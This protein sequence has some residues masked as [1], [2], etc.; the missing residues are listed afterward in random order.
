MPIHRHRFTASGRL[1]LWLALWLLATP[2]LA[3]PAPERSTAQQQRRE[4]LWRQQWPRFAARFKKLDD[5]YYYFPVF[6]SEKANSLDVPEREIRDD[7]TVEY[8]PNPNKLTNRIVKLKVSRPQEDIDVAMRVL[9][10]YRPGEYGYIHSC[11]IEESLGEGSAIVSDI[12]LLDRQELERQRRDAAQLVRQELSS[13][14][15][16]R[17]DPDDVLRFMFRYRAKAVQLEEQ[18]ARDGRLLELRGFNNEYLRAQRVRRMPDEG[19]WVGP[20]QIAIVGEENG[21]LIAVPPALLQPI[22]TED[23][24]LALLASHNLDREKFLDQ[25]EELMRNRIATAEIDKRLS[26]FIAGI[27]ENDA[28]KGVDLRESFDD[29]AKPQPGSGRP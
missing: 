6:D 22:T 19:E 21:R 11:T 16:L 4:R 26:Y 13:L 29:L 27:S 8:I 5:K 18:I 2:L 20:V 1:V 3:Q 25:F 24:F 14:P 15:R 7:I 12:R 9:P 17:T 28:L 10:A 23:E